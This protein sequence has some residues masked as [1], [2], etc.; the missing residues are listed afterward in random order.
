MSCSVTSCIYKFRIFWGGIN[1]QMFAMWTVYVN[2]ISLLLVLVFSWDLFTITERSNLK[3]E[4]DT[5]LPW[6][7][8]VWYTLISNWQN[9]PMIE[10]ANWVWVWVWLCVHM[11]GITKQTPL[12]MLDNTT[13]HMPVLRPQVICSAAVLDLER[14]WREGLFVVAF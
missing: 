9:H 8:V 12:S 11:W 6:L 1:Y 4:A 3:H 2:S 5:L 7:P 13:N 14:K 10:I